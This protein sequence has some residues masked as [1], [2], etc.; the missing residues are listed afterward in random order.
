MLMR[1]EVRNSNPI[2][3]QSRIVAVKAVVKNV[4]PSVL[5]DVNPGPTEDSLHISFDCANKEDAVAIKLV[6]NEPLVFY[7]EVR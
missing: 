3:R 5:I 7:G 2:V 1:F 4:I 6:L